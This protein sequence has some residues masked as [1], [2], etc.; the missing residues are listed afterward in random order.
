MGISDLR[1]TYLVA[2]VL[3]KSL[4]GGEFGRRERE[5]AAVGRKGRAGV[6][7]AALVGPEEGAGVVE[8]EAYE[9]GAAM[10]LPEELAGALGKEEIRSDF[11]RRS[12]PGAGGGGEAGR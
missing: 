3:D 11:R 4:V 1:A 5:E 7:V 9:V 2:R 12:D 10:S 8:A 6:R